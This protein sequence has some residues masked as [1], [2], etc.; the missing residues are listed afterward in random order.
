MGARLGAYN[1]Q[2]LQQIQIDKQI[3]RLVLQAHKI[4]QNAH[5]GQFIHLRITD[6]MNPLLRRPFS[7]HRVLR[8]KGQIELLYRVIGQGTN[9]MKMAKPGDSFHVMGPLG[10]GFFLRGEFTTAIVVAGGMGAA[11]VFFLI[12]ELLALGKRVVFFWGVKRGSELFD[13]SALK[14]SGIE[15]HLATEDG[16]QG[17]H[18]LVTDELQTFLNRYTED[19]SSVGFVCGPKAMLK[20][21]Q[22]LS[23]GTSFGWQ[24]S[25]EETMACGIGVCQ[26][27]AVKSRKEGIW[28]VCS[29]G[30]VFD[31]KEIKFS[32]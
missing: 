27:C 4:A 23:S 8:E 6:Q 9:L 1:C 11:P 19:G 26:G 24:V 7:I 2:V 5:S 13:I 31:L 32:G 3:Y 30:P 14:E 21:I 10:K 22:L 15:V 12:D 17:F 29:D 20:K 18:G 25:L 28:M 16:S